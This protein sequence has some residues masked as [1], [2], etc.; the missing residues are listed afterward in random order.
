MKKM[1]WKSRD[2]T[3]SVVWVGASGEILNFFLLFMQYCFAVLSCRTLAKRVL[4]ISK[5]K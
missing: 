2:V 3:V 5:F 1:D 4:C